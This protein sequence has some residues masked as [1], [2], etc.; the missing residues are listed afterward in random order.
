MKNIYEKKMILILKVKTK[1]QNNSFIS[2]KLFY[3]KNYCDKKP[4][5]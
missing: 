4:L 5:S 1:I 2:N 3:K